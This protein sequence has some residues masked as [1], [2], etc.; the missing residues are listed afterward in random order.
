M[1]GPIQFDRAVGSLGSSPIQVWA[2]V[3][4]TFTDCFVQTAESR[5]ST[6]VL[7]TGVVRVAAS[8]VR[9]DDAG[10]SILLKLS[11]SPSQTDALWSKVEDFWTSAAV[12]MLDP[13]GQIRQL[14]VATA[15]DPTSNQL[16]IKTERREL[17][18]ASEQCTI[19]L[20]AGLE[21]PVL[22]TRVL[23]GIPVGDPLPPLDIRLGTTRGTNALL[24]RQGVP[25]ILV[26]TSGFEDL[27]LIGEQDRPDLFA[28]SIE[29]PAPL[30]RHVVGV[31]ER[32]DANGRVEQPLS[33]DEVRRQLLTARERLTR[34]QPG[35]HGNAC[36]S[37]AISL[38]NGYLN[39]V[40]EAQVAAIARD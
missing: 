23:L 15:F 27:L 2:D 6:K 13:D 32:V 4:G 8:I 12:G 25:T 31:C 14:G 38:L 30:T 26:T 29:K 40:H 5:R 24:T 11:P 10:H 9:T 21:A 36:V 1:T 19:E 7:S 3:G 35:R 34:Q 17:F 39:D 28:L 37:L 18:V 16:R 22:A 33:V 20:N